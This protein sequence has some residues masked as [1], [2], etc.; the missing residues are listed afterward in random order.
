M[1]KIKRQIKFL[2]PKQVIKM[3]PRITYPSKLGKIEQ[4]LIIID[5]RSERKKRKK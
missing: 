3:Y 2:T 4:A 1:G 5:K